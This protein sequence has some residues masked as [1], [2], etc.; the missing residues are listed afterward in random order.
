MNLLLHVISGF[1]I[2]SGII[3]A[4][5]IAIDLRKRPQTMKIMNIVWIL[6]ALWGSYLALYAY[7]K[8]GR[9]TAASNMAEMSGMDMSSMAMSGMDMHSGT[10]KMGAQRPHWQ[11]V[12]LSALHCGAG[13]TLADIVGEWITYFHPISMASSTLV[14]S[15]IF[16]FILALIFGVFFQFFAIREMEKISLLKGL[17]RAFRA[18]FF[19]L[20][21]WQAGMYVWMALTYFVFFKDQSLPKTSFVFWFMM[22]IAMLIGFF[23]AYPM[24]ALLIKLGVKKGM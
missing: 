2:L 18:D 1:F 7:Y 19:S 20:M 9:A 17:S 8:F 13:C 4:I 11:S 15:W 21:S 5:F 12:V 14:G 22:Q 23:F 3:I 6:S 10:M 24:N 16:D